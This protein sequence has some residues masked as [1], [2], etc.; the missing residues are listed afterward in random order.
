MQAQTQARRRGSKQ[1]LAVMDAVTR[2][3]DHPTA[4][5]IFHR[6]RDV[7]PGTSLSTVYRNLRI[8]VDE[9]MLIAVTGPG[10]EVHYD[11][12]TCGHCHIRCRG[13]GKVRDVNHEPPDFSA[14]LP[15]TEQGFVIEGV[16]VTF[17]GL[18]RECN[19]K[20]KEDGR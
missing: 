2:H 20:R 7:L 6:V 16:S 17:T 11:H 1:K 5:S 12:R 19:L 9:G 8:L 4:D 10:A 13:C 14:V 3:G 18:C 15:S